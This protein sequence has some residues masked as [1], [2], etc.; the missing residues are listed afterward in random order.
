MFPE[1]RLKEA[2][3]LGFKRGVIPAQPLSEELQPSLETVRVRDLKQAQEAFSAATRG[4][5]LVLNSATFQYI[6]VYQ[7]FIIRARE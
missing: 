3:M 2:S 6:Y 4:R 5:L 1:I 7:W